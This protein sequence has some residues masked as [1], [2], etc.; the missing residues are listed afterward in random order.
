VHEDAI[1]VAI[2]AKN[3]RLAARTRRRLSEN[4]ILALNLVSSP[5]A[6]KTTLLER[7]ISDLR[8]ERDIQVIEGDQA[9]SHDAD[10]VRRAGAAAIQIN[11]GTGCHLDASMVERGLRQLEP[12][13]GA[14]V[15][16]E[17]VGNLVCP[18][19]FDLGE[20]AKV[21]IA[22]VTEG[23]DKP[24]KY[25]HMFRA[26]QLVLLNKVDLLPHVRFDVDL[27][28]RNAEHVNS[29][30]EVLPISALGGAGLDR[31]YSWVRCLRVAP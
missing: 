22:S 18:A 26:S 28:V 4:E 15:F 25:P 9:T 11:T 27:F 10:R 19:L 23:E 7:T 17:N 8:G 29:A 16:I 3:D 13:R 14:L 1:E 2:L 20:R 21:L 31:W 5:G 30:L 24:L 6:G 12:R